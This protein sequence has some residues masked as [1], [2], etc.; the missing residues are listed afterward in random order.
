MLDFIFNLSSA[1]S[2]VLLL[3][4]TPCIILPVI[5]KGGCIIFFILY[6]KIC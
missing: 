6:W 5:Y 1:L 2:A 4:S 3:Y